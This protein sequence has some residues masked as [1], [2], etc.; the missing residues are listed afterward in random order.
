[1]SEPSDLLARAD[2]N[3]AEF[4]RAHARWLPPTHLE[5]RND[6]LLCS[7]GTNAPGPWNS[8]MPLGAAAADPNQVLHEA[9]SFFAAKQR[10][11][12]IYTRA[13]LDNKLASACE[14]AGYVRAGREPGMAL[15]SRI[16]IETLASGVSVREVSS[17]NVHQ[18]VDVMAAAYMTLALPE[19]TTRKLLS[20]P[21][22]WLAAPVEARLLFD[23]DEPVA[24]GLLYF[25]H[26]IAGVY[27]V[28]TAPNARGR[29]HA[30]ALMRGLSNHAFDLG[31][32]A[33]TLQASQLGEPV[34][35]RIGYR[36]ITRYPMFL[37]GR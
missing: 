28:A 4:A 12:C 19:K 35:R 1:M 11:F 21:A 2:A 10:S 8:A 15:T 32:R 24:G 30:A 17:A 26:G 36:E 9:R 23:H 20:H 14:Q 7:A 29:G 22:R 18:F 37:A 16:P 6:L 13:H 34:Y 25:S 33:V 27:W 3:F 31:A 5:E